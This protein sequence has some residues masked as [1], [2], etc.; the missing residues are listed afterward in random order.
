[1]SSACSRGITF[2]LEQNGASKTGISFLQS[3]KG[4]WRARSSLRVSLGA[5][6]WTLWLGAVVSITAGGTGHQPRRSL[7]HL[8]LLVTALHRRR[9]W[10]FCFWAP[11]SL[12]RCKLIAL[13]KGRNQTRCI[14]RSAAV[15][16]L[17]YIKKNTTETPQA[18]LGGVDCQFPPA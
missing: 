4:A 6:A 9:M 7:G 2:I 1:M 3:K 16:H 15:I 12:K 8:Q 14:V 10:L 18:A 13:T 5:A 11:A 17:W